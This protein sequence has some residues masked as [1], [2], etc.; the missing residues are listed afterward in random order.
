MENYVMTQREDTRTDQSSYDAKYPFNKTFETLSGHQVQFDDTPGA[1]RLFIRHASGTYMEIS[2]DGKVINYTV[3]DSK[4][5]NK[6]GVTFT[7][8]ENGDVKMSGH[9]RLLVGGGAEIE[10]SGDCGVFAGG[11]LAA[12]V[13]GKANIRAK[14]AYLGTDGDIN[15]N[16]QGNMNIKVKGKTTMESGGDTIIKANHVHLNP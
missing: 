4:S 16:S 8:D 7:V 6:A 15:I 14:Q 13:M 9:Q 10:V 3:G 2:A 12:A 11:D 5:Y 1:E